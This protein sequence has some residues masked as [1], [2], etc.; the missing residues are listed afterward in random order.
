MVVILV[1]REI[2]TPI[3]LTPILLSN[4]FSI[5]LLINFSFNSKTAF[6]S[7]VPT[8]FISFLPSIVDRVRDDTTPPNFLQSEPD[9]VEILDVWTNFSSPVKSFKIP[10]LDLGIRLK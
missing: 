10:S 5:F 6:L 1:K 4:S 8:M 7:E 2:Q 3:L 9:A